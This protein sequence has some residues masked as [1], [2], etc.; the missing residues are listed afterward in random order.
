[1]VEVVGFGVAAI[2]GVFAAGRWFG[3]RHREIIGKISGVE[4]KLDAHITDE[5]STLARLET[6]IEKLCNGS[7]G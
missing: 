7:K 5:S 4:E 3:W 6:R 2:T 1:M